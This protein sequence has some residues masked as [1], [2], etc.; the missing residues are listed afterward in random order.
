MQSGMRM[1]RRSLVTA[2]VLG[3]LVAVP[4]ATSGASPRAEHASGPSLTMTGPKTNKLGADFSYTISGQASAS[5]NYLVVWEQVYPVKGCADT[6]A[7]ESVRGFFSS[8]YDTALFTNRSVTGTYKV[9][10]AL[11]ARNPGKHGLCAYLI[12]STTGATYAAGGAFWD[13]VSS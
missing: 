2:A 1:L 13:N 9:T 11:Y 3:V 5:A 7:G 12:S 6:Y 8:T 10:E 4:L